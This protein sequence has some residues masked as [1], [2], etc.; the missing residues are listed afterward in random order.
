MRG[1]ASIFEVQPTAHIILGLRA[2]L[3]DDSPLKIQFG[4]A[5]APHN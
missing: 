5:A 1:Q 4:K 3:I 2:G